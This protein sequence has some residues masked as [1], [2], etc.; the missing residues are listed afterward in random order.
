MRVP[1]HKLTLTWSG[2]RGAESS[3]T[4]HCACGWSESA[5]NQR[6]CRWEYLNHLRRVAPRPPQK[7]YA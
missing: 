4:A 6:E 7:G 1:G 3:S 2:E 5:S